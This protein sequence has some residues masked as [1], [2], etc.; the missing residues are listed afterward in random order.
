MRLIAAMCCLTLAGALDAPAQ[1]P[2]GSPI[3]K[4]TLAEDLQLFSQVLNQ[5]RVNH[6][7]TSK[8]MHA[9][10]LSAIEGMVQAA[11]PHSYVIPAV[12]LDSARRSAMAAGKLHPV[13]LDF[14]FIDGAPIVVAVAP[15]AMV[16][17][18][19][20]IVG[21]ELI[22]IDGHPI[23]ANSPEEL[24][25]ALAGPKGTSIR[26]R[27]ERRRADGSVVQ[28]DRQLP[29]ERAADQTAIAVATLIDAQTGYVRVTT[30]AN[31]KV[32]GDLNASIEDLEKAGMKR[33]VLDL[34][35]NGGG[36]VDQA[37]DVA[38]A[39]LPRGS[40]VYTVDGPKKETIDTGRVS[41][42]FWKSERRFPVVVVVNSGTASASELVTAALQD[43]DRAL[44]VGRTTFGKALV[45]VGVPLSDG[46]LMVLSV[47]RVSTPCGRVVQREYRGISRRHYLRTAG[48]AVDTAGRASCRT[49][50][51]RTVYGGGGV[52]PDV[53]LPPAYRPTWLNRL[54]ESDA[55][56]TWSAGHVSANA[57]KFVS[58]EQFVSTLSLPGESIAD[59]RSFAAS[60]GIAIPMD[61]V[62]ADLLRG[63][64]LRSLA[65]ARWGDKGHYHVAALTDS[66]V[67]AAVNAFD[68]AGALLRR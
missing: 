11:D 32:A 59:F 13:L 19:D 31:D 8:D 15:G 66:E 7:D 43:H 55:L 65:Y 60:R 4:R 57:A 25:Y 17:R 20:V 63:T 56:L 58:L 24:M 12:R 40:M 9:L 27:V 3:R 64:L 36:R 29:R 23:A 68:R 54:R 5:I 53:I 47:G 2:S 39:F 46:S 35:D 37:A 26:V 42:I 6:V 34:R 22:E 61:S 10:L 44:V 18:V 28:L 1:Q 50:G 67:R 21:D 49:V 38:G 14:Q 41:R 16:S 33:L 45:M 51:G 62:D 52:V 48:A 30:F